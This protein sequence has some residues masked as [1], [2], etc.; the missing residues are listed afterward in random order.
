MT[1][2]QARQQLAQAMLVVEPVAWNSMS[3]SVK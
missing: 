2:G 3:F 1:S